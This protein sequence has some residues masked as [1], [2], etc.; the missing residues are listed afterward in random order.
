MAD[1]RHSPPLGLSPLEPLRPQTDRDIT[2]RLRGWV[3]SKK[4]PAETGDD[5]GA[6]SEILLALRARPEMLAE[7][8]FLPN[9]DLARQ[10]FVNPALET[11][12]IVRSHD[13]LPLIATAAF[14]DR[15]KS[16]KRP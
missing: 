6:G 10:S 9:R 14:E 16:S 7:R 8:F 13:Y 12:V 2:F 4:K 15:D 11:L 5:T 3:D 1:P